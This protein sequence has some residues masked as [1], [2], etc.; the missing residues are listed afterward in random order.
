MV[1]VFVTNTQ[2]VHVGVT[3]RWITGAGASS[4]GRAGACRGGFAGNGNVLCI[5][6]DGRGWRICLWRHSVT[7][8]WGSAGVCNDGV[9]ETIAVALDKDL[10]KRRRFVG[11]RHAAGDRWHI[12]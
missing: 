6:S 8:G 1:V 11:S 7:A 10:A 9:V 4:V 2:V 3:V 5:V 12:G